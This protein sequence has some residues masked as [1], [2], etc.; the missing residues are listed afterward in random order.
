[1]WRLFT[2]SAFILIFFLSGSFVHAQ[3]LHIDAF[4]SPYQFPNGHVIALGDSLILHPGAIVEVGTAQDITVHG[5]FRSSGTAQSPV[6]IRA[7]D[8]SLGWG[9]VDIRNTSDSLVM[10][11]SY[12]VEGRLAVNDVPVQLFETHITN[13]QIL[14]WDDMV[15]RVW[16]SE[17]TMTHSSITGSNQGEGLICHDCIEPT[18]QNC[19]FY[20]IPDAIEFINCQSGLIRGNV[21]HDLR[22]DAVDLNNCSDVI[23]DSNLIYNVKD[24]GLEIG[25]ENFG[26]CSN[27]T[28]KQNCIANCAEAINFKEGST[29]FVINNTLYNN[30]YGIYTLSRSG[31]GQEIVTVTNCIFENNSVDIYQDTNSIVNAQ[32]SCFSSQA[33]DGVGNFNGNPLLLDPDNLNFNLNDNSPCID[34]GSPQSNQDIDGSRADIGALHTSNQHNYYSKGILIWPVPA[35]N[36]LNIRLLKEY[37]SVRI[38]NSLGKE[39]QFHALSD[40]QYLL[41]DISKFPSGVYHLHFTSASENESVSFIKL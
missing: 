30:D 11:Y 38:L 19:T 31:F 21:F 33:Y 5:V 10:N 27:I 34:A 3:T 41:S 32:Y 2:S 18:I 22:D 14:A 37:E 29:G 17:V 4:N 9:I 23:I 35:I 40:K 20:K 28:V 25:S 15:F 12:I 1:M 16:F 7:I 24:R 36:E 6:I 39:M 8:P 26:S 13:N